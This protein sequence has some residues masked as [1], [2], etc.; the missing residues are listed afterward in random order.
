[1]KIN[2]YPNP[3]PNRGPLV[4]CPAC[5]E[6]KEHHAKGYCYRCYRREAWERK[7]ITCRVCGRKRPHKSF[8]LCA[9]CY[10][11]KYAYD[12]VLSSNVKKY[13]GLDYDLF[14]KI[15]EK[16]VCCGF[17]KV[18]ELHHLD[19]DKKH[20]DEKNLI[21]LCPNC[22]K[23]IHSYEYYIEI[24]E[25]LQSLGYDVSKVHPASYSLKKYKKRYR[26]TIF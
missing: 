15:T 16:C 14:K 4:D 6:R 13:Y 18:V 1:M 10:T 22:H 23:L 8:G 24:K 25:K 21:G 9:A 26:T 20:V 11:R 12:K 3:N 2:K 17:N 19:G 5:G 7:L